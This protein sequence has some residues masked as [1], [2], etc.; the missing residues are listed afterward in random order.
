MV[1]SDTLRPYLAYAVSAQAP[2]TTT[3]P[4]VVHFP[5]AT[6]VHS[7]LMSGDNLELCSRGSIMIVLHVKLGDHIDAVLSICE[8]LRVSE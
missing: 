5:C 4:L 3:W 8:L 2:L 6:L 7:V 1:G